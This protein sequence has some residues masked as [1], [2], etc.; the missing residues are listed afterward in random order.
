MLKF[1]I[2]LIV[3][4]LLAISGA[5][6]A[7]FT[8]YCVNATLMN[9]K[10]HMTDNITGADIINAD[11]YI[12]CGSLGCNSVSGKCNEVATPI[13]PYIMLSVVIVLSALTFVLS[14]LLHSAKDK[15]I[16]LM[17]FFL[18]VVFIASDLIVGLVII[19]NGG[20][21]DN[22]ASLNLLFG[23]LI[24]VFIMIAVVMG[25]YMILS[26]SKKFGEKLQKWRPK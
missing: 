23:M 25:L 20:I 22:N 3:C 14:F 19:L 4:F 18:V 5:E 9:S 16:Q 1:V 17:Y 15:Y 2:P 10:L 6:A 12:D 7:Y 13:D 11:N 24:A 26:T 21:S 8:D